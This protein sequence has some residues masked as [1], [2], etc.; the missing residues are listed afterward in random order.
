MISPGQTAYVDRG[1]IGESG[2]LIA[3]ILETTNLENIEGYL[4]A[5]DFEKAFDSLNHNLLTAV[6]KKFGFGHEFI[7][8][9]KILLK[10]QKSCV[11]NG[12]HT[13]RVC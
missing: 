2:R 4:L 11:M 1:F 12:G 7:D 5:I 3:D 10:S 8:W 13:T 6:L 9:I